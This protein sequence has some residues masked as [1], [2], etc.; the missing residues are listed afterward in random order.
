MRVFSCVVQ[1]FGLLRRDVLPRDEHVLVKAIRSFFRL[2]RAAR[3]A[4]E[5][6]PATM[7]LVAA[8]GRLPSPLTLREKTALREEARS[9]R[10]KALREGKRA[11][12]AAARFGAQCGVVGAPLGDGVE[13]QGDVLVGL[14]VGVGEDHLAV[15]RDHVGGAVGPAADGMASVAS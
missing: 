12:D 2:W 11:A 4:A 7:A 1:G 10:G 3:P 14:Q 5:D 9:H 15:R 6:A 13:G 8:A